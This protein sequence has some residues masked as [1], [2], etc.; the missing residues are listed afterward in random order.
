MLDDILLR[1][2]PLFTGSLALLYGCG[3][4]GASSDGGTT[5][6]TN[7][8]SEGGSSSGD[9]TGPDTSA[10]ASDTTAG[11]S[12]GS[13]G[14]TGPT[15]TTGGVNTCVS[16]SAPAPEGWFGPTVHARLDPGDIL[17][18]CPDEV[19]DP[20]PSLVDG[21]VDPGP[22]VCECSCEVMQGQNCSMSLVHSAESDC[23]QQ[24]FEGYYMPYCYYNYSGFVAVTDACTNVEI[25]GFAHFQINPGGG[26]GSCQK[27]D[28]ELIPPFSWTSAIRTCRLPADAMSCDDGVCLPE[29]PA[30]FE[31]KWCIYKEGDVE[32]PAGS[33][34]H[35]S[36]FYTGVDDTRGCSN[37]SCGA[38]AGDCSEATLMVFDEPDCAG[39]PSATITGAEACVPA[40]GASV[41][42]DL[43]SEGGCPV[44]NMAMPEGNIVPSGAFTF[45]CDG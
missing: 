28:D 36:V 34:T 26:G 11:D 2:I 37:C 29:V 1:S 22:A 38:A 20:G 10:A 4:G 24:C 40:T 18:E 6:S 9:I 35:K 3:G 15:D 41:A 17:P 30:G 45:C 7:A 8:T 12:D 32:C 27:Q 14:S 44:T 23:G 39:E 5:T 25:E 33:F 21:F 16:C 13:G 31:A 43:G 19:G 42:A